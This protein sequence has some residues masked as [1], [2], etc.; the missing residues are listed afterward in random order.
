M[1]LSELERKLNKDIESFPEVHPI[2]DD[3]E[4]RFEGVS[5]LVMLDRYSFKD[6]DKSTLKL[7][8]LVLLTV[9]PDPNFPARGTGRVSM[10]N[11]IR[12]EVTVDIDEEYQAV[13]EM[14]VITAPIDEI[15]KPMELYY[16]QIARRVATGLAEAEKDSNKQAQS[17]ED[18]YEELSSLNFVPAG[19]VLYGAGSGAGVTLFN[20]FVMG[21]PQDN[22]QGIGEH[23]NEVMEIMRRGGGVGTNGSTLRPRNAIARG[24]NGKSSGAVSWLNDIAE[25]THLVEQGGSRRGKLLPPSSAMTE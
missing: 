6:T 2:T 22:C 18:F 11:P 9:K 3:M 21:Y 24:V 20:C 12:N 8:D 14:D 17:F 16:E 5:R 7:G 1:G 4:M 15:D 10:I 19:R 23:R 25:L 13:A